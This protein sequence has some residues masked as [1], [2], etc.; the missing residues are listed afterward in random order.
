MLARS[1]T[2]ERRRAARP[3]KG[4]GP[5]WWEPRDEARA[6]AFLPWRGEA[7]LLAILRRLAVGFRRLARS[8]DFWAR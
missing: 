2:G 6:S 3:W 5:G 8:V 1:Q 4:G 7:E